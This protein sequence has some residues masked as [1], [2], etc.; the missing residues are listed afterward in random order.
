MKQKSFGKPIATIN[1]V[2]LFRINLAVAAI[3]IF[4]STQMFIGMFF[5]SETPQNAII[6][7]GGILLLWILYGIYAF[8]NVVARIDIFNEGIEMRSLFRRRYISVTE[9]KSVSFRRK[10]QIALRITINL[11]EGKTLNINAGKYK[12]NQPVVDFLKKFKEA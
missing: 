11:K 7:M 1:T 12:D 2:F 3:G 4:V 5:E 10:S 9:I 8:E 6:V